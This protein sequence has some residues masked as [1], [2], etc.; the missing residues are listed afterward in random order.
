MIIYCL[1]RWVVHERNKVQSS[2]EILFI[3]SN[4]IEKKVQA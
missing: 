4:Y 2:D 3:P 1:F